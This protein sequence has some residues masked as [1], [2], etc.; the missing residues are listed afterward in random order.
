MAGIAVNQVIIL[1]LAGID[2]THYRHEARKL[3]Y[4]TVKL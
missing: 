3:G 1:S 2:L 4:A